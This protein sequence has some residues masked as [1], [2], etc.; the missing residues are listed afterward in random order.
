MP[1]EC[2]S[3]LSAEDRVFVTDLIRRAGDGVLEEWKAARIG[4]PQYEV[5]TKE[6]G[7]PVTSV[8]IAVNTCI[9]EALAE[10]FPDDGLYSEELP[11]AKP[12]GSGQR[13]WVLDPLDGTQRFVNGE[14]GFG[15]LLGLVTGEQ[16]VF[17]AA[18]FP[19]QDIF[20]VG[21]R[22]GKAFL[23]DAPLSLAAAETLTPHSVYVR[24]D[25][26]QDPSLH[27]PR[28]E[29]TAH[30]ILALCAGEVTGLV[31]RISQHQEWDYCAFTAILEAAGAR[32]TDEC[33]REIPFYGAPTTLQYLVAAPPNLHPRLLEQLSVAERDDL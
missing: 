24:N 18:Y 10:R 7:S 31:V 9:A 12:L 29:G 11:S 32:V 19:A 6:D 15:V 28:S 16:V 13:F 20:L 1:S 25:T 2:R 8:D 22:R 30:G 23:N 26:L 21:E 27:F 33:G 3:P 14:D 4:A 17:G 5:Q